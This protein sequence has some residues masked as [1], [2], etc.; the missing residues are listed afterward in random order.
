MNG[1]ESDLFEFFKSLITAG[2]IEVRKNLDDLMRFITI[3]M[4][5]SVMP[6]FK[7][8]ET[9]VSE[10][11]GRLKCHNPSPNK[12]NDMAALA[13]RIVHASLNSFYTKQYDNFQKLTNNIEQ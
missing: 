10:I 7:T 1:S 5:N 11:E 8:P 12:T 13:D 3:M 2:L 6:C 4:K 9:L